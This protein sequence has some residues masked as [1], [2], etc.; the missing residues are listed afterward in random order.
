MNSGAQPL[1]ATPVQPCLRSGCGWPWLCFCPARCVGRAGCTPASRA[2]QACSSR[3]LGKH[4]VFYPRDCIASMAQTLLL[5]V[6]DAS[7][8][9]ASG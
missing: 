2:L 4:G 8:P 5:S 9:V 7:V 6:P 3:A 1:S